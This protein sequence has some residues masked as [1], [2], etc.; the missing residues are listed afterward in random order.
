MNAGHSWKQGKAVC[1]CVCARAL[2]CTCSGWVWLEAQPVWL[3]WFHLQEQGREMAA[4][5]EFCAPGTSDGK[6]AVDLLPP[7]PA[8]PPVWTREL[9]T[10]AELV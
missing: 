7:Q 2:T 8:G 6:E 5:P 9:G 10:Q 1:V 4:R 3:F